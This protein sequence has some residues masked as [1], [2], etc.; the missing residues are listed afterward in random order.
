MKYVH[1]IWM[2]LGVQA[3]RALPAR[4]CRRGV[5]LQVVMCLSEVTMYA[6]WLLE[7]EVGSGTLRA[8]SQRCSGLRTLQDSRVEMAVRAMIKTM[9][10][11]SEHAGLGL[12]MPCRYCD[13][14]HLLTWAGLH[15]RELAGH[16]EKL[17]CCTLDR[18]P[19]CPTLLDCG[20]SV[21][22]SAPTST[23]KTA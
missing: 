1:R 14:V 12:A 13:E 18:G 10:A 9:K 2:D 17:R 7:D 4:V 19:N 5:S 15:G 11:S 22:F 6:S 3:S 23:S 20:L 21:A 16:L 8:Q